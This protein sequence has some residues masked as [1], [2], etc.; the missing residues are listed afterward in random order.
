[1]NSP[2]CEQI[3][4][5]LLDYLEQEM[6]AAE[7]KRVT[8]H[9][10]ECEKCKKEYKGLRAML[11]NAKNLP[12]EDPGEEFW[13]Q[14]PLNVLDEV[15]RER[16]KQ[17]W[18]ARA[19]TPVNQSP[20][21]NVIDISNKRKLVNR[22]PAKPARLNYHTDFSVHRL[23]AT[24][25]I[26]ATLLL[27]FNVM[28]F[29]PKSGFLWFDQMQFQAHINTQH[30]SAVAKTVAQIEARSSASGDQST[31]LGFVEQQRT[32]KAFVVGSWLAE[33]FVYLHDDHTQLAADQLL[34]LQQYL[35][36]RQVSAVTL[37]TLR[38]SIEILQSTNPKSMRAA[39]LL[40]GF[41]HDYG[42]YLAHTAPR[43]VAL[44]RSG[45][46]VFNASLAV[47]AKDAKAVGQLGDVAQMDYLQTAFLRMKA[48]A[49]VQ[50]SLQ[51]FATISHRL[52]GQSTLSD[53]DYRGLQRSLQNLYTLLA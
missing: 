17:A 42:N 32:D 37:S 15:R 20:A 27:V 40:R 53:S 6:S 3:Q 35:Q 10:A 41:Q 12:I 5:E 36:H 52:A 25:A 1:M 26:A 7:R 11:N 50:N 31:R 14:L 34:R 39:E 16:V 49:G 33:A 44:Y 21:N 4:A 30:L 9:L 46:W 29:S 51:E 24:L 22:P 38:K 23:S 43:Q 48:P 18:R 47:A 13:R 19:Q 8:E 2:N 28:Q 45:I